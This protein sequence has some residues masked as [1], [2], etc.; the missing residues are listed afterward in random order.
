MQLRVTDSLDRK[1]Q[2][3]EKMKEDC[4]TSKILVRKWTVKATQL[5]AGATIQ[6]NEAWLQGRSSSRGH[7]GQ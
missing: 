5:Q 4:W 7:R 3:Q 2:R 1:E 6:E